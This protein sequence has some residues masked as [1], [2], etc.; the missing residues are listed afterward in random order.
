MV[1]FICLLVI[2][3]SMGFTAGKYYIIKGLSLRTAQL[4]VEANYRKAKWIEELLDI[5]EDNHE[6]N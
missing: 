5:E 2:V 6:T 1:Y 4:Y 3:F